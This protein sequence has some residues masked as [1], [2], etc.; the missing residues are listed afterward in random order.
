[1][2]KK[3]LNMLWR[4]VAAFAAAGLLSSCG[5]GSEGAA[6]WHAAPPAVEVVTVQAQPLTASDDLPGRIEPVR[7]A[8]V[9]ARVAGIVLS[10]QFEEG[11]D[12]K[13]G[14]VL[15]QIDPAPFKASLARAEAALFQ[16]SATIKRYEPL[17]KIEAVSRQDYDA[18]LAAYKTA[19]ANVQTAKLDLEYATVKAPIS[20]RIGRALV[21]EGAL[22]GQGEATPMATIQ[23]LDPVYADFKQ[24][25]ADALRLR[26]QAETQ[27]AL[28]SVTIPGLEQQ[29]DGQLMFSDVT[30]DRETGQI[31]LRG[32]FANPDGLLLPGM[33]VRVQTHQ[34]A[35]AQAIL[36]PQRAVL[37][38]PDGQ[39]Q[40][41]VI[42]DEEMAEARPVTTG[43]MHASNWHITDGL[44]EGERVVTDGANKVQPG[45][46]VSI[47]T[48]TDSTPPTAG[49]APAEAADAAVSGN[50]RD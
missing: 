38:T 19:V 37:R 6:E 39:A 9:R 25:A 44:H 50:A 26:K 33:Y 45:Q 46:K 40:V 47:L 41:F 11:T 10:R 2:M 30:V 16:A 3:R 48:P 32:Q 34:N 12:V 28:L 21:T 35:H 22:V 24:S 7:L 15:F 8:E 5:Q 27:D 36:V 14:Q 49:A 1:M 29:Y 18:A 23:Q 42:N 17:V 20:G 43:A 31:L 13:A 4:P